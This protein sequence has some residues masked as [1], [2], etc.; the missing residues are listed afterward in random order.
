MVK[1]APATGLPSTTTGIERS[2]SPAP[3]DGRLPSGTGW[4][5]VKGVPLGP[6]AATDWSK[7]E[8]LERQG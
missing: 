7:P 2:T 5:E 4:L 3:S 6:E 1:G 8:T